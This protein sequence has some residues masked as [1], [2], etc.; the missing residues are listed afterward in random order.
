MCVLKRAS[1][2]DVVDAGKPQRTTCVE[3][4]GILSLAFG[5]VALIGQVQPAT[6]YAPL[7]YRHAHEYT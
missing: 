5:R 6:R 2:T 3:R 7:V 1:L 4:G